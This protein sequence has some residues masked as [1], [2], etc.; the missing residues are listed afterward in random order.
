MDID[1]AMIHG[2]HQIIDGK[3]KEGIYILYN[4]CKGG[5]E[6]EEGLGERENK[7]KNQKGIGGLAVAIKNDLTRNII[8]LKRTN[9]LIM[10]IRLVANIHGVKSQY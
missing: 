2:A 7:S 4:C 5:C 1:I 6:Q 10:K 8:E 3:W 9:E